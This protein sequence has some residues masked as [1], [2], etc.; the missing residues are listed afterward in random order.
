MFLML[1]FTSTQVH[2]YDGLQFMV[3][4]AERANGGM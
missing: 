1:T 4:Y 2:S 3:D